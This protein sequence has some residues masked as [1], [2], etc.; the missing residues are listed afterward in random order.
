MNPLH[1]IQNFI[2]E[3]FLFGDGDIAPTVPLFESGVI[4]STGVLEIIT[5]IKEKYGLHVPDEDLIPEH[6]ATPA[7]IADYLHLRL[8]DLPA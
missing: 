4:D 8:N 2:L 6:F 7:S 1:D 3:R 5:F